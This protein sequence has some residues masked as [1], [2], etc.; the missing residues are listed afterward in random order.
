MPAGAPPRRPARGAGRFGAARWRGLAALLILGAAAAAGA[1]A[2]AAQRCGERFAVSFHEGSGDGVLR[3]LR[4]QGYTVHASGPGFAAV[5]FCAPAGEEQQQEAGA[6][7]ARQQGAAGQEGEEEQ[8]QQQPGPRRRGLIES[9]AAL[10]VSAAAPLRARRHLRAL[11][12]LDGVHAAERD[13]LRHLHR[14]AP[15]APGAPAGGAGGGVGGLVRR[16]LGAAF[17][18]GASDGHWSSAPTAGAAPPSNPY[19]PWELD[20]TYCAQQDVALDGLAGGEVMPWGVKAVQGESKLVPAS[21]KGS[22]VTVCIID[23][24]VWGGHPDLKAGNAL[25]GCGLGGGGAAACPFNWSEDLVAHGTHVAGT[26]AA[27]RNGAGVVGVIPGGADVF[28]VRIWNTSGDVSQGQGVYASDLVRAYAACEARL[29]ALAADPKNK[30]RPQRMVVSMSFGSAGPLTVERMWF[31]RA[32]KRDDMLFA[33]SS[34]NNG[35]DWGSLLAPANTA[36]WKS[37]PAS[38]DVPILL[39]VANSNCQGAIA[40]SSQRNEAVAIAAPGTSVRS[41]VPDAYKYVRGAVQLDAAAVKAIT[42]AAGGGSP[43]KY[44]EPRPMQDAAVGSTGG[45]RRLVDCGDAVRPARGGDGGA[46]P[47]YAACAKAAGGGVCMVGLPGNR[48]IYEES[49]LAML[50]C[51]DGGGGA[52]VSWRGPD[53]EELRASDAAR[54]AAPRTA[55]AQQRGGPGGGRGGGG[56]GPPLGYDPWAPTSD[57]G[58][59]PGGL[60][61]DYDREILPG[62]RLNCGLR[63]E[64][65]VALQGRLAGGKKLLPGVFVGKRQALDML[66]ALKAAGGGSLAANV[67]AYD[68]PYRHYDG[69]SMAAP[70]VA[71]G[72]ARVWAA[73]PACGARDVAR[74]L[75]ESASKAAL[76]GATGISAGAGLL[77]VEDA[78]LKLKSYPCAAAQG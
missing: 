50:A 24:G 60:W 43:P 71:G 72:A 47:P 25:A 78:Y 21:T 23:S 12:A 31:D 54:A 53:V 11:A 44:P 18:G 28:S 70:H 30:G 52:L 73:F 38:Y 39:S 36:Q 1:E 68:Y 15:S 32:A 10:V 34:G 63:C 2:A 65:W 41:T 22:G 40:E 9:A 61:D 66:N 62:A 48:D 5:S 46:R 13:V 57:M 58:R 33:A 55:A 35:S 3:Q 59:G 4:D 37:Y 67:T 8:Q 69:T 16:A 27:P 56:S 26:I 6:G 77:Q 17:L 45:M 14:P 42:A 75:K 64:C 19:S 20:Q 51:I 29:D 49:C 7:G 76:R 74:A